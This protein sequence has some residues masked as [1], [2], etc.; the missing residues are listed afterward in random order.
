MAEFNIGD[1]EK[2]IWGEYAYTVN[3]YKDFQDDDITI[4]PLKIKTIGR[5]Y[6]T[7]D[8]PWETRFDKETGIQDKNWGTPQKI[9]PTHKDAEDAI[10][11]IKLMNHIIKYLSLEGQWVAT[12]LSLSELQLLHNILT[13]KNYKLF[14]K[15]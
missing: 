5:R 11:R 13:T 1:N 14:W 3:L 9:Y 10:V 4:T 2:K 12:T 15:D 6:I 7:I 8:D